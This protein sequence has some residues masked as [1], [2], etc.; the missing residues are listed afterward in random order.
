MSRLTRSQRIAAKN[1]ATDARSVQAEMRKSR[2][3]GGAVG[4][5]GRANYL[6]D[7]AFTESGGKSAMMDDA[8]RMQRITEAEAAAGAADAQLLASLPP[9]ATPAQIEA[10]RARQDANKSVAGDM[11]RE[12]VQGAQAAKARID[13]TGLDVAAAKRE[14]LANVVDIAAK[15]IGM[16]T[17]LAGLGPAKKAAQ[18]A[19]MMAQMGKGDDLDPADN[20]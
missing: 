13:Q 4:A 20:L 8:T 2:G 11:F 3:P 12:D 19:L 9:D 14:K 10:I 5:A 6:E 18:A 17:D 1:K 15:G 16:A 7:K